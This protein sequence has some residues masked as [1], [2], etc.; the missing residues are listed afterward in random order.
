MRLPQTKVRGKAAK[1]KKEEL[2][3]ERVEQTAAV[4]IVEKYARPWVDNLHKRWGSAAVV[5]QAAY[6]MRQAIK[7]REETIAQTEAAVRGLILTAS[8]LP[9]LSPSSATRLSEAALSLTKLRPSSRSQVIVQ[10]EV[11]VKKAKSTAKLLA[12]EK[13]LPRAE[14]EERDAAATVVQA[15][16]RE[17][18]AKEEVKAKKAKKAKEE[19]EE[20][21]KEQLEAAEAALPAEEQEE[22]AEAA[23]KVQAAARGKKGKKEGKEKKKGKEKADKEAEEA[24]DPEKVAKKAAKEAKAA[25]ELAAKEAEKEAKAAKKAEAKAAMEE[26][27]KVVEKKLQEQKE[28][29]AAT[30]VQSAVRAGEAKKEVK[31]KKVR[32]AGGAQPTEL[33]VLLLQMRPCGVR[34]AGPCLRSG[35]DRHMLPHCR[36]LTR[37]CSTCLRPPA[38]P[39]RQRR[40][41]RSRTSP[42]RPRPRSCRR[43]CAC[44]RPRRRRRGSSRRRRRPRRPRPCRR[45]CAWS[46]PRRRRS[47]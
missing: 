26:K 47:A 6:R 1:K 5:M 28:E 35:W 16:V 36:M 37:C 9:P 39:R 14:Q 27:V 8:P 19:K 29:E 12:E 23:T 43:M 25:E 18:K 2:A 24:A 22:R 15:K 13:S 4:A 17:G 44:K 46:R 41:R 7:N 45:T 32:A 38:R 34:P 3:E 20:E 11:R 33:L 10:K 31:A 21:E 30:K 42:R 40:I